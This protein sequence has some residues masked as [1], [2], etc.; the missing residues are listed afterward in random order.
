MVYAVYKR[1]TAMATHVPWDHTV[2][3]AIQQSCGGDIPALTPTKAGTQLSR[4]GGCK[5]ELTYVVCQRW[6]THLGANRARRTA[7]SL[8]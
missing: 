2:L 6:F 4:Y 8:M 7:T 5:A 1:L 3:P